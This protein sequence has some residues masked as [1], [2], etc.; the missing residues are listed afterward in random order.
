MSEILVFNASAQ[1]PQLNAHADISSRAKRS[2][3]WVEPSFTFIY[4]MTS[5]LGVK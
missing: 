4:H 1:K 5:R 2:K 3:I